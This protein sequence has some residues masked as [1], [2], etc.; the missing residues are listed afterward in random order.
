MAA[1]IG[2]VSGSWDAAEGNAGNTLTSLTPALLNNEIYINFHTAPFPAGEIRGQ[3]L[4]QDQGL[5]RI[6]VSALGVGD[7][8]QVLL[9]M[10]EAGG[11]TQLSFM[12]NGQ[13]SSLLLTGAPMARLS[14][15]DFI[16][17]DATGRSFFA[18]RGNDDVFGAAGV[19]LLFGEGGNDRMNSGGG[20]D[21]VEG[22]DGND[23]I[24]GMEGNDRVSGG[25]GDDDV[26]GNT[27]ADTAN[28]NE[29]SDLVRGGQDNDSVYGDAG[30]DWHVNGNR[31]EDQVFGGDGHD[32][33]YGGQ[34]ADTVYGEAGADIVSGD[35]GA[36]ILYGGVGAD[37][38]VLRVGFGA[39]WA[40]D[41]SFADGDRIQLATGSVYSMSSYQGQ[42]L[43]TLSTGD[44]IGLA[45]VASSGFTSEWVVFA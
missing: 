24:Q 38:F 28:G 6:D 1:S 3:M 2:T 18:T 40:G 8:G 36:D 20:D 32:T 30:D 16:F 21:Q 10:T 23:T 9:L 33:V 26:T 39:D 34:G 45:G 14:A 22:R 7:F 25:A 31:G 17:A 37:R 15:A 19:D 13:S 27:G 42:V 41:F 29:G 11:T 12:T 44:S 35:L 43:I 5:D 4:V